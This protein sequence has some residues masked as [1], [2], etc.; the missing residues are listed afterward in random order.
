[1][2]PKRNNEDAVSPV[3]GVMLMIVITVVIAAVITIFSTGLVGDEGSQASPVVLLEVGNLKMN[4]DDLDYV[5]FVHKGGDELLLDNLEITLMGKALI[6]STFP[7]TNPDGTPTKDSLNKPTN[8]VTVPGK[9]GSGIVVTPGDSI[10]VDINEGDVNLKYH[11]TEK[12]TWSI[13]DTR[14]ESVLAQGSF[15][16]PEKYP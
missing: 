14:T 10:R 15:I 3:V 9:E 6:S 4:Y 2:I 1:M 7:I 12:I 16:V 13:Y 11:P 5:E 8:T